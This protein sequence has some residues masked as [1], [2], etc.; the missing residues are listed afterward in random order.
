MRRY[1]RKQLPPGK[2]AKTELE[3]L[4]VPNNGER[5]Y[6][7]AHGNNH[8]IVHRGGIGEPYRNEIRRRWS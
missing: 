1:L 2:I 8:F 5:G 3:T 6:R 4:F 7:L